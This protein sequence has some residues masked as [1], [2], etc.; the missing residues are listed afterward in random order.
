M[1]VTRKSS[2]PDGLVTRLNDQ[3]PRKCAKLSLMFPVWS[4]SPGAPS[5]RCFVVGREG[6]STAQISN[7]DSLIEGSVI[8]SGDEPSWHGRGCE[9]GMG[10]RP[11]MAV[12]RRAAFGPTLPAGSDRLCAHRTP[13]DSQGHRPGRLAC[14]EV[15]MR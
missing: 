11:M 8:R 3:S 4:W 14:E 7:G 13:K 5:R 15:Q 9:P 10:S 2:H 6:A 12:E 1:P